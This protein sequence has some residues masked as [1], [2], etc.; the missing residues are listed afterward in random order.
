MTPNLNSFYTDIDSNVKIEKNLPVIDMHGIVGKTIRIDEDE[1]IVQL[2]TDK[3]L[4]FLF[5]LVKIG[6]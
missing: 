4:E 2:L 3:N 6:I 1:A 5:E